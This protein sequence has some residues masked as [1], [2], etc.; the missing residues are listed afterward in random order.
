MHMDRIACFSLDLEADYA[1]MT[2]CD[3]YESLE[4]TEAFEQMVSVYGIKLTTFVAGTI[5]DVNFPIV[6]R[7]QS[8][9]S[10]F[11]THS[12]SH[13]LKELPSAKIENIRNGIDAYVRYFGERP[14][15]YRAPQGI[16]SMDEVKFLSEQGLLYSSSIFPSYLPGRYNNLHFPTHPFI[17]EETCLLEIPFSVIPFIRL[18]VTASH[19]NLFGSRLS[20][21]LMRLFGC[22]RLL[23]ICMHLYDFCDVSA[24]RMLPL[25]E[26]I[27]YFR[28]RIARDKT[29]SFEA[30]VRFLKSR[31]YRFAYLRDIAS[32][33]VKNG[34]AA[35][36]SPRRKC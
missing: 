31:G 33:I 18:P 12:Y 25:K 19:V 32:E 13:P 7:L 14:S 8:L 9:G 20:I 2:G 15:G 26:R 24:Y 34:S 4:C 28:Q 5:L 30:L 35:R 36:W 1:G 27:G 23:N 6:K 10:R 29:K 21:L 3:Y 11:E 22:P 17:Y 16:I